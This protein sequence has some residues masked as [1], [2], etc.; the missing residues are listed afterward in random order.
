MSKDECLS[1][2]R[3][4]PGKHPTSEIAAATG[5]NPNTAQHFMIRLHK[6][7]AVEAEYPVRGNMPILWSAHV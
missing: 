6:D 4:H 5:Q 2:L 1:F 7:Q 3:S